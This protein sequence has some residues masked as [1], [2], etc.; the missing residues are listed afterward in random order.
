MLW[1]KLLKFYKALLDN[2]LMIRQKMV[3]VTKT[4]GIKTEEAIKMVKK[5]HRMEMVAEIID[6]TAANFS[7]VLEGVEH[8]LV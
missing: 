1:D 6:I 3:E 2:T 7:V 8:F 5:M 4:K